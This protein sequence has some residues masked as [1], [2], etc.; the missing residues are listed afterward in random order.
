MKLLNS[1][2]EGR[3]RTINGIASA[4]VILSLTACGADTLDGIQSDLANGED[5]NIN[6]STN[7]DG[8]LV[9]SLTDDDDNDSQGGNDDQGDTGDAGTVDSE[10]GSFQVTFYNNTA[11]QLMTPPVVAL[12][13]PSVHLFQVGQP[14]SDAIQV[15]A[16]MGNNAPLVEFAGNNPGV[17]SAAGVAGDGPFGPGQSVSLNL[18]TS[19]SGQ[20]FSAVNMII[21]TNDGIS[22]ADSIHLP[23]GT[24]P[25]VIRALPYD[26]GTRVNQDDSY[27]FFPPPCRTRADGTMID[28]N[29][30]PLES[31]RLAIGPHAGQSGTANTPNGQ[32]W[33]FATSDEV[34]IIEIVRTDS[35][36]AA[37]D[38]EADAG[39]P[40]TGRLAVTLTNTSENQP[41]T[42][43]VVVLHN[44][45]DADNGVRLFE[46]GQPASEGIIQIA[47]N[48]NNA[49]LVEAVESLVGDSVS[50]FAVGFVDP[51]APGPLLPGQTATVHLDLASEDQVMSIVSMVVCTNDGFSGADSHRLS[52]DESE[53]FRLP[54]YDAGSETNVLSLNYW[55]PPCS[56]DGVS[57]NL[58]DDENGS[59]TLH[60]GQSGSENPVFDF[61][62]G[63][64]YLEVTITRD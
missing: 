34:L 42:P 16:E 38:G 49:P 20:V 52:A 58:T 33:D 17:V 30:A 41:M 2:A 37:D 47:E 51:S 13:D 12:H 22:G 11:G 21:C 48:G 27:S 19:R 1:F 29:E 44:A 56:P 60:P 62:S 9:I 61:E 25:V 46:S 15:I 31:P 59:V 63:T 54:I 10:A 4:A 57:D 26:A 6:L 39:N 24:D 35:T 36:D 32:N 8:D 23:S 50:A 43:P 64:R 5:V 18:T 7:D 55:V 45:P 28:V 40:E 3:G 53:T 14:A